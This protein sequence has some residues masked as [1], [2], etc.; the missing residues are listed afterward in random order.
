[1]FWIIIR[2]LR[3]KFERRMSLFGSSLVQSKEVPLLLPSSLL[4]RSI[5]LALS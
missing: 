4:P 5:E 1:M 3:M 2:N